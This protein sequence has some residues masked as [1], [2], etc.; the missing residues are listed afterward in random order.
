MLS[1]NIFY[2]VMTY[3][4]NK[5]YYI[6]TD[7]SHKNPLIT[8]FTLTLPALLSEE[9]VN[10]Q[11]TVVVR[12]RTKIGVAKRQRS[13]ELYSPGYNSSRSRSCM[14]IKRNIMKLANHKI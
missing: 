4:V 2:Y 9:Y 10:M 12:R 11:D 5:I 14:R 7:V 1:F 8:S 3:T 13:T 6:S